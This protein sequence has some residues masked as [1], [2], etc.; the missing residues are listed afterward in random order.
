MSQREAP[1]AAAERARDL[2]RFC[3][4]TDIEIAVNVVGQYGATFAIPR[5]K[6]LGLEHGLSETVSGDLVRFTPDHGPGFVVRRY[7]ISPKPSPTSRRCMTSAG[8]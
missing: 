7:D 3:A 2:D 1:A 5:V 4:D 6:S 8:S